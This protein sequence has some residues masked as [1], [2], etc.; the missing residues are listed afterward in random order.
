MKAFLAALVLG[1]AIASTARAADCETRA[2]EGDRFVVCRYAAAR[3]EIRILARTPAGPVDSLPNLQRVLGRDAAR[4]AFAM[5]AGMYEPDQ[6]PVGL[7]VSQGRTIAPLNPR[8]GAGNFYLKPNGVFW[9]DARGRAHVDETAAFAASGAAAQW[10][11]Q[12]GPLLVSGGRLH[13]KVSPNG[14][15]LAVRNA[16]G[17]KG[18]EAWF[19]ISEGPVSFGRLAR[20]MRDQL[21]CGDVLYLDGVVSSLWAPELGRQDRRVGLGPLVVVLARP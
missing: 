8:P 21:G 2:F 19:V 9:V 14:T 7:F 16:V 18:G 11:T 3:Q 12:S 15:A 17:A 10:A 4:V 6:S 13:P 5:N 20:L 1:A